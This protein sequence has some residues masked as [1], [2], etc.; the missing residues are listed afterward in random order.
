M[1]LG[2]ESLGDPTGITVI[3]NVSNLN[4]LTRNCST[5]TL[6][7]HSSEKRLLGG[8]GSSVKLDFLLQTTIATFRQGL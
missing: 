8:Q 1:A 2:E 6:Y 5:M 7:G 3:T 4:R